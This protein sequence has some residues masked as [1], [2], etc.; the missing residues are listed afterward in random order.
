MSP[1]EIHLLHRL[2]RLYGIETGFLNIDG[3]RQKAAPESLLAVLSA[4]GASL[5]NM[6][7]LAGGLRERILEHWNRLS[8]PVAIAWDKNPVHLELRLPGSWREYPA[9]CRLEL[10]NGRTMRW[11]CRLGDLPLVKSAR[12]EGRNY[13]VR[14]LS[15][16][17]ALPWGYHRLKLN[18]PARE[19]EALIISAPRR[20]FNLTSQMSGRRLWGGFLPLYALH[21]ARSPGAGDFTDLDTL[22]TW[23]RELGGSFVGTLPLL[24]SFLDQAFSPSPYEPV[25]R[26]FWNE[27]YIDVSKTEEFKNSPKAR[28]LYNSPAIQEAFSRLRAKPLVDYH[29]TMSLKRKLL[30]YCSEACFAESSGRQETLQSWATDNP[31]ARDYARFRAAVEKQHTAWTDWPGPMRDGILREGDY[32]TWAGRYHL[33]VQWLAHQQLQ[34][35]SSRARRNG[36]NLYLDFPLGVH[37]HGYDV[38][39]ERTSFVPEAS[40]GAPPDA[41]FSGGQNWGLPPLH[42]ERIRMQGYRYYID[43]LR[44]HLQYAGILRLDHVMGLHRLF[45]VPKGMPASEGVYVRYHAEEFYAVLALESHRSRSLL[46]GEDL[47]LVPASVRT[48]MH[49][50]N[51]YRM[52]VMPFEYTKMPRELLRDAPAK[53]LACLNTHD[54]PPFASFWRDKREKPFDRAALPVFLYHRGRLKVPTSNLKAV[55]RACLKHLAAGQAEVLLVNLEDLWQETEPQNIPGTTGDYPNWQRKARFALEEF[56]RN[57]EVLETLQEINNSREV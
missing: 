46:V 23:V 21:S 5:S 12:V 16:P 31:A 6:S 13:E 30:E 49:R 35:L 2:C 19:H 51:V 41:F 52:Y 11:V 56:S 28:E 54:M 3:R 8:E 44:N 42:P 20:A 25:S 22:L 55:F 53:T 40:A 32:D 50:H 36:Q 27:F 18:L 15:L 14:R 33:Y 45:W 39:R 37:R 38:W 26:L 7:G 9:D 24:A 1:R 10:E 43:S 57:P 29:R 34:E 4:L 17:S 47:G 48:A